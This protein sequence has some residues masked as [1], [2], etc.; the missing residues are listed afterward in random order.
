MSEHNISIN[1]ISARMKIL[2]NKSDLFLFLI[3]EEL[4][5]ITLAIVVVFII[6]IAP[7]RGSFTVV[8]SRLLCLRRVGVGFWIFG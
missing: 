8:L 5:F 3:G 4:L 7:F 2:V 6:M 1:T